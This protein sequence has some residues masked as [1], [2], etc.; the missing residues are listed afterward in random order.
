[1]CSTN[2]IFIVPSAVRSCL[3]GEKRDLF[4]VKETMAVVGKSR[5][6]MWEQKSILPPSSTTTATKQLLSSSF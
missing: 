4:D 6:S 1:M 3:N 2:Q 5:R